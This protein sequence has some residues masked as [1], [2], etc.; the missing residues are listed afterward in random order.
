MADNRKDR[1]FT[2][3][4][5][6]TLGERAH[7]L[8]S[9][10]KCQRMTTG[11]HSDK[12]KSLR[13]GEAAH[14]YSVNSKIAR[15]NDNL[16]D[17]QVRNI[18]NGI[19]LCRDCHKQVDH[20]EKAY[21]A[22]LLIQWKKTH[23]AYV[24]ALRSNP[25]TGT[26]RLIKPTIDEEIKAR[27][28]LDYLDDKRAFNRDFQFE[29]PS[30]VFQ[31]LQETRR[32]LVKKKSDLELSFLR[33]EIDKIIKAIRQFLDTIYDID[34]NNLRYNQTDKDWMKFENSLSTLRKMIG[35]IVA[36]IAD[37]YNLQLGHEL[38]KITP[39]N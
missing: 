4:I 8:C 22:G 18:K 34:I 14:I 15:Y 3:A 24:K 28:I 20:D 1:D 27:E 29:I 32:E 5:V 33:D 19:W 26:L 11:P 12:N 25:N 17:E 31:S 30:H 35:F 38:K 9:N 39:K 13:S 10:P 23:E 36:E 16:T 7:F 6:T 2:K 21:P 37:K